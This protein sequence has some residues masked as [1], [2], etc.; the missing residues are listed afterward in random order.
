MAEKFI[1]VTADI[2]DSKK[3]LKNMELIST[4]IEKLNTLFKNDLAAYFK[5]YRGDEVQC[6]LLPTENVMKIVRNFRYALKPYEVRIGIGKGEID[7]NLELYN[8]KLKNVNPW[9]NNGQAFYSARESLNHL[10][11]NR[12][13]NKKPRTY[14]LNKLD[15]KDANNLTIN[16]LLNLYDIVLESWKLSQW[17]SILAYEQYKSLEAAAKNVNKSYQSIQR[18]VSKACWDEVK[19]CEEQINYLIC[20]H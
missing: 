6:V 2:I 3:N 12:S 17:D 10:T 16:S 8:N 20:N 9:E 4:S 7:N 11:N 1:V 15:D 14:F 13:L 5:I 19:L 18:S